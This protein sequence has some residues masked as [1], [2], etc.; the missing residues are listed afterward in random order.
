MRFCF[1]IEKY[2]WQV[3]YCENEY[4]W[5]HWIIDKLKLHSEDKISIQVI[6]HKFFGNTYILLDQ[7]YKSQ[8]QINEK[9]ELPSSLNY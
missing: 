4:D 7:Y 3:I 2:S 5:D 6:K 9:N 1:L 8:F